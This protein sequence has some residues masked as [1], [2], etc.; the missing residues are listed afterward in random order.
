M[1][2]TKMTI[3]EI[4]KVLFDTN[5]YTVIGSNELSNKESRDYLYAK[6]DQEQTMNVID[7][8][9]HLLIW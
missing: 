1:E 4:R 8:K 3:R 5:K 2:A 7:N 9:T 6:D